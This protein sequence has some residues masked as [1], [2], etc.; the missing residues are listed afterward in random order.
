MKDD[1][2]YE[3]FMLLK[4]AKEYGI[5]KEEVKYFLRNHSNIKDT[6]EKIQAKQGDRNE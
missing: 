2:Y 3:W 4:K 5:S 1:E 6:K